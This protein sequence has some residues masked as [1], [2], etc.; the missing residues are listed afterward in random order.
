VREAMAI[1]GR[2]GRGPRTVGA[3]QRVGW[4]LAN[5]PMV[6]GLSAVLVLVRAVHI[7]APVRTAIL[8]ASV[9]AVLSR[10]GVHLD[11]TRWV[12]PKHGKKK[13]RPRHSTT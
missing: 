4:R 11:Q 3:W 2:V 6:R 9:S 8:R 12:G 5:E 10:I 1:A 13:A 7:K